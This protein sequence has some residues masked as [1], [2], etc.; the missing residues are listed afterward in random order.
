LRHIVITAIS[1]SPPPQGATALTTPVKRRRIIRLMAPIC[2]R[3]QQ[4]TYLD[5]HGKPNQRRNAATFW[6]CSP[7]PVPD[8]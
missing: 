1:V 3:L 2:R 5:V 6:R 4:D 7:G 8:G